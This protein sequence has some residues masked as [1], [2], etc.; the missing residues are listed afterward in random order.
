HVAIKLVVMGTQEAKIIEFMKK[1]TSQTDVDSFEGV[2]PVLDVLHYDEN[3]L[4]FV[5]P[6]WT[7][8]EPNTRYDVV[9]QVLEFVHCMLKGLSFLHENNIV[10]KDIARHNI[11]MNYLAADDY[12]YERDYCFRESLRFQ[13]LIRYGIFDFNLSIKLPPFVK[14]STYR[15]PIDYAFEGPRSEP[16]DCLHGEL[17]Y[18]PFAYDVACLGILFYEEFA[19]IIPLAPLLA[20]LIDK[21]V[22]LDIDRRFTASQALEFFL[23]L[24][25][26]MSEEEL[27]KRIPRDRPDVTA[28]W[29]EFRRWDSLPCGFIQ[30]W[31]AYREP[32][33]SLPRRLLRAFCRHHWGWNTVH[34]IRLILRWVHGSVFFWRPSP[35]TLLLPH[36][37]H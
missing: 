36:D 24:R 23:R 5:T 14:S 12:P 20:P 6:R 33:P 19:D 37:A 34:Y 27:K 26:E 30:R 32:R 3:Y 4:F 18:R 15:L 31:A 29:D 16:F 2:V 17:D 10:H 8:Y 9:D 1:V 28:G 21:M 25:S 35:S 11:L 13:C 22:T 7:H